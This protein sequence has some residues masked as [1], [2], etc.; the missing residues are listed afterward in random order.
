MYAWVHDILPLRI[1][2]SNGREFLFKRVDIFS[3]CWGVLAYFV[4]LSLVAENIEIKFR[5]T[6]L[7]SSTL[8]GYSIASK[9]VFSLENLN[10]ELSR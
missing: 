4:I 2:H 1:I 8:F 7:S 10:K 3:S 9:N 6:F 5:S